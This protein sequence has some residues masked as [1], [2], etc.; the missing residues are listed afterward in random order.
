[1]KGEKENEAMAQNAKLL[2]VASKLPGARVAVVGD[3]IADRY[4]YGRPGKLS[5]EAPVIVLRY[6]EE[7]LVPKLKVEEKVI[8]KERV[9]EKK[10][11]K[12]KPKPVVK[13]EPKPEP[14][15]KQVVFESEEKP[16]KAIKSD[17]Y[18][19]VKNYLD[20]KNIKIV[21]SDSPRKTEVNLILKVPTA[22]GEILYYAKAKSKKKCN[23]RDV[24][25]AF[26]EGQMK[27]LPV[28]FLYS[29]EV[30]KKTEEMLQQ[31]I[32]KNLILLH[33]D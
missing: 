7:K 12:E 16:K 11:V 8:E 15:E 21:E 26:L 2:D 14:V 28:L 1:M 5:R 25:S 9:E 17:F 31:D 33:L 23:D 32:F 29:G 20:L 3:L 24:S 22:V 6:E 4:V 27:K 18:E 13:K 19:K 10:E 30:T